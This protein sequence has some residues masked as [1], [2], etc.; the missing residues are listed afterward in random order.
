MYM[1]ADYMII[2]QELEAMRKRI[3]QEINT[4]FDVIIE[5]LSK[6]LNENSK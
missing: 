2:F 4:E 5:H 6:D 3:L 1:E